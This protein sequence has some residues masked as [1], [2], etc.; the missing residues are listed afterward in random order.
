MLE[1]DANLFLTS[2]IMADRGYPTWDVGVMMNEFAEKHP[3]YVEKFVRAEC[4]GIDFWL[5]NPAEIIAKELNLELRDAARMMK[6]S[7]M[8]PCDEQLTE[9]YIGNSNKR[10]QFVDDILSTAEFL[11]EQK[12]LPS[13]LPRE[14]FEAFLVPTYLETIVK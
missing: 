11:H 7:G 10:G 6:G 8:V 13:V 3:D 1:G 14:T 9:R 12:R 4:K 5:E 2:G